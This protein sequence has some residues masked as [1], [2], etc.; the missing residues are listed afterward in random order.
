MVPC[1]IIAACDTLKL[2]AI[3]IHVIESVQCRMLAAMVTIMEITVVHFLA[4]CKQ[5]RL[6]IL[7]PIPV[8]YSLTIASTVGVRKLVNSV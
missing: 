1:I 8:N 4:W 5:L 7:L 2:K 6:S 3:K